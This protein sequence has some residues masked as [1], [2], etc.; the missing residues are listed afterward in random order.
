MNLEN[1]FG[2]IKQSVK[3]ND[4][5][6][7]KYKQKADNVWNQYDS[8]IHEFGG[9]FY[10]TIPDQYTKEAE[11][12]NSNIT[13]FGEP[14]KKYIEDTLSQSNNKQLYGIEFGGPGSELFRG[15]KEGLFAKTAGVCLGDERNEID[16]DNDEERNHFVFEGDILKPNDKEL[17]GGI[18]EKL[19]TKKFDCIISR[20]MG[21]V[22]KIAKNPAV[23]KSVIDNWYEMLN[24]NGLLFAQ[25]EYFKEHNPTMF[26]KIEHEKNPP[27]LRDTEIHVT[28][29]ADQIREK[30]NNTIDIQIGRGVL[31]LHKKEGAPEKLPNIENMFN[32]P[33]KILL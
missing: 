31:R 9:T 17:F 30:S 8:S 7:E 18:K 29:W 28:Y 19:G 14:F 22:D 16:F 27:E 23:L 1:N 2:K 11:L 24:N 20:L 33:G 25:F 21:P 5:F 26:Q 4:M 15:F 10:K 12:K 13:E 3:T 6:V 32:N